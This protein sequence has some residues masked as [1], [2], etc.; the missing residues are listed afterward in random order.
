MLQTF[1]PTQIYNTPNKYLNVKSFKKICYWFT[2]LSTIIENLK[3]FWRGYRC[4]WVHQHTLFPIL[5]FVLSQYCDMAILNYLWH[6]HR[7]VWE[8]Y[9]SQNV[10]LLW[11]EKCYCEKGGR[12]ECFSP[13][14]PARQVN[15]QTT[16]DIV[17]RDF[18]SKIIISGMISY[19]F[20]FLE[21]PQ[22]FF[23]I[24]TSDTENIFKILMWNVVQNF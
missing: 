7:S 10:E 11:G 5:N 21:N 19:C 22:Y 17:L 15:R 20:N 2:P 24:M 23:L 9:F 4:R 8:L 1:I 16:T 18:G 12:E 3:L 13:H 6:T 14:Q